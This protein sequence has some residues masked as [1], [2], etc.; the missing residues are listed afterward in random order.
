MH[1]PATFLVAFLALLASRVLAT[2]GA[3]NITVG[4]ALGVIPASDFLTV[5]MLSLPQDCQTQCAPGVSA[6]K[7]C[8]DTNTT[9]LCDAATVSAVT[10]CQ[11]CYFDDLIK[12]NVAPTDVRAGSGA[13]ATACNVSTTFTLPSDWDGPFGLGLSTAGTVFAVGA[14]TVLGVGLIT[15]VNTM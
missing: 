12:L 6:I 7:A 11:Q 10:A 15:V 1:S 3:L 13:Y 5:N 8:G 2:S 4:G 14:A 9:C